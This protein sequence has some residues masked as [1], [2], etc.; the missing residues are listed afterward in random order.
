MLKEDPRASALFEKFPWHGIVLAVNENPT[1]D[2]AEV[3]LWD[4]VEKRPVTIKCDRAKFLSVRPNSTSG[5]DAKY[6]KYKSQKYKSL[7]AQKEEVI[8]FANN[9]KERINALAEPRNGS[10][11]RICEGKKNLGKAGTVFWVKQ[12]RLGFRTSDVKVNG[13]YID[14]VWTDR[15]KVEV[16]VDEATENTLLNE[17]AK[18]IRL[19]AEIETSLKEL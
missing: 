19:I 4:E 18:Y 6:Q 5:V 9:M 3:V 2:T 15:N 12:G 13:Q 1:L 14:V 17:L 8:A 16:A 10:F 11:V 7:S